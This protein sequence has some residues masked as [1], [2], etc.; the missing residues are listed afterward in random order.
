M[1]GYALKSESLLRKY[2]GYLDLPLT[3]YNKKENNMLFVNSMREAWQGNGAM[4]KHRSQLVWF[5]RLYIVF[6]RYMYM[7]VL[8]RIEKTNSH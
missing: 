3:M 1:Q 5:R 6:S 7:N 4:L 2:I 8:W